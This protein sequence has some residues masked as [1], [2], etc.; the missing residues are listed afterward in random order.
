MRVVKKE[1]RVDRT[2]GQGESEFSRIE[3]SI[4]VSKKRNKR[5]RIKRR[6]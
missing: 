2:A 3:Y 1:E 6:E 5:K 4:V